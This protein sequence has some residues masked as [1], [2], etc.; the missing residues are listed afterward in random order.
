MFEFNPDLI[1]QDDDEA[2]E[3]VIER[4]MD[5]EVSFNITL[6]LQYVAICKT[7]MKAEFMI[8]SYPLYPLQSYFRNDL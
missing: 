4:E 6:V 8:K 2:D 3:G 5:E 7:K 1:E